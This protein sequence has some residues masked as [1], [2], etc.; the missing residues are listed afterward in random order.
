MICSHKIFV[1][2]GF[3]FFDFIKNGGEMSAL[4]D[5]VAQLIFVH[6]DEYSAFMLIYSSL[7][8]ANRIPRM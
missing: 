5:T 4:L 7:A 3:P 6:F 1:L 8:S 2:K